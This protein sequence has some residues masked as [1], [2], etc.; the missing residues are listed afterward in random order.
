MPIRFVSRTAR[1]SSS[2]PSAIGR[3]TPTAALPT[4]ASSR[5]KR[6]TAPSTSAS[7]CAGSRRSVDDGLGAAAGRADRR[8]TP[9]P[10]RP[11]GARPRTTAMPAPRAPAPSPRRYPPTRRSPRPRVPR[12]ARVPHPPS[13]AC[14][15]RSAAARSGGGSAGASLRA[16]AHRQ[17]VRRL[18]HGTR[19]RRPGPRAGGR[20]GRPGRSRE[21]G[22]RLETIAV[23]D[24][25]EILDVAGGD[26]RRRAAVARGARS[27][28]RAHPARRASPAPAGRGRPRCSCGRASRAPPSAR[29]TCCARAA[30][31]G[32]GARQGV[33][34]AP[35]VDR[36][37]EARLHLVGHAARPA[38]GD[39]DEHPVGAPR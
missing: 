6:A 36:H 21:P 32:A 15:G 34:G 22:E 26:V 11:P 20:R 37:A 17:P 30:A 8:C 39:V 16:S 24:L 38:G 5:P 9:P 13:A 1:H 10:A 7:T 18:H 12:A 2:R 31:G 25:V 28:S 23:A 35:G 33:R 14:S 19:R 27:A 4:T 29:G 3:R